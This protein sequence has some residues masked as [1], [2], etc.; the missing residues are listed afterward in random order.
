MKFL[1]SFMPRPPA[2]RFHGYAPA[3]LRPAS[4][5]WGR[6]WLLRERMAASIHI[7]PSV[8]HCGADPVAGFHCPEDRKMRRSG[9]KS[10]AHFSQAGEHDPAHAWLGLVL[11]R[12]SPGGHYL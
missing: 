3:D 9:E 11:S 7:S 6:S 8:T 2:L 1:I 10:S 12:D 5:N 4:L